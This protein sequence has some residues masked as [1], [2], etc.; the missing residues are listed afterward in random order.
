MKKLLLMVTVLSSG[1]ASA[2]DRLALS[3]IKDNTLYETMDG[4]LSN[5]AGAWTFIGLTTSGLRRSIVAF[6]V[7][8]LDV[9]DQITA[10]RVIFTIDQAPATSS[11]G[12]AGLHLVLQDWGEGTSDA[13]SPGGQ[14]TTSTTNDATWIHSFYDTASWNNAG[15]DFMMT[16]SAQAPFGTQSMDVLNFTS[17][18]LLIDDVL[19]WVQDP[20]SN[21]GW[22]ILGD[23]I[24]LRNARRLISKDSQAKETPTL[25]IDFVPGGGCIF[26]D[27][28]EAQIPQ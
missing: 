7:S 26:D 11:A 1:F 28:F 12:T 23:E 6:D 8:D 24:N 4:S 13:L 21:Y 19:G 18:A 27:S 25:L 14:G 20:A 2:G 15:G 17:T 10:V 9:C 22:I 16:P 3:P 5:G